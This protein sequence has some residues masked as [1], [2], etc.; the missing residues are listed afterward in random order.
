MNRS[1]LLSILLL[2]VSAVFYSCE[3]DN[4]DDNFKQLPPPQAI[5]ASIEFEGVSSDI[6]D[7]T[8]YTTLR[9]K[10]HVTGGTL[11]KESFMFVDDENASVSFTDKEIYIQPR[12]LDGKTHTLTVMMH[13][14]SNS[15]SLADALGEYVGERYVKVRFVKPDDK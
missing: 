2:F 14:D 1:K 12:V 8:G 6:I 3:Y 9:Y 5:T 4:D 11:I 10:I 15:G 13:V 7:I